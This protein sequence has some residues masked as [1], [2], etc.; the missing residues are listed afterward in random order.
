MMNKQFARHQSI[1]PSLK[2]QIGALR[3]LA[4]VDRIILGP[5]RGVRHNRPVGSIKVQNDL[6]TGIKLVG[7][8]DRGISEFY[9]ITSTIST[10]RK[11]LGA[12]F[13]YC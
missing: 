1:H 5:S 8:S 7:F 12:R 6:P 13:K 2:R 10:V 3:S 4:G 9:L 11:E